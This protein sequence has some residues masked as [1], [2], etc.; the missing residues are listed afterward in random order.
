[1]NTGAFAAFEKMGNIRLIGYGHDH[2]NDFNTTYFGIDMYYGRK[3]GYGSYGPP[4]GVEKGS[5]IYY[6]HADTEG[7]VTWDSAI[8]TESG[9]LLHDGRHYRHW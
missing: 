9:K 4:K 2:D 6:V 8:R 7:N 1:M 5:R 3:T